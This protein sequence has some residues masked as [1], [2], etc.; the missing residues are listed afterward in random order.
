MNLPDDRIFRPRSA[1]PTKTADGSFVLVYHGTLA[2]RLGLD[3]A[4]QAV[5]KAKTEVP[6][7]ELRIIGAGEERAA[8]LALRDTLGLGEAVTFSDG[9]VPVQSVPGLIADA[10]AGIVPLRISSGTDIMLPTKLLEYVTMGIPCITPKTGT[11]ARYFDHS[12]VQ[13]F[14]AENVDSLAAAIVSLAQNPQRRA[15]LASESSRRFA[16]VYSWSQHKSVY[17]DLVRRL[18]RS[19]GAR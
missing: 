2:R 3:L 17:I 6:R 9:F 5:A 18:T 15:A 10:D 13:F 11:I 19:G 7:I 8:L 1:P 12:M 4:I 16:A 14:E